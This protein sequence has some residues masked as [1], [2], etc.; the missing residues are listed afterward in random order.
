MNYI[1]K[2]AKPYKFEGKEYT[3]VNLSGIDD[4]TTRDICELQKHHAALGI[5]APVIEM[6]C[7]YA[8]LVAAK[9]TNLPIEF[10]YALPAR[11]GGKIKQAVQQYF[12]NLDG[13]TEEN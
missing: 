4:L 2:F 8:Q 5:V 3:E 10:Y 9:V 11:E 6:D 13:K 1:I 12:L 7:T